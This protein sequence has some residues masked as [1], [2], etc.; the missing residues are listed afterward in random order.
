[1]TG[2]GGPDERDLIQDAGAIP[3]L[4]ALLRHEVNSHYQTVVCAI[5]YYLM[6]GL[7][8][9]EV[10][11]HYQNRNAQ[12]TVYDDGIDL[13]HMA[14]RACNTANKAAIRAASVI[15]L[16]LPHARE[17]SNAA[18]ALRA[19]ARDATVAAEVWSALLLTDRDCW[20]WMCPGL[21]SD[22][23][24][25]AV[26]QLDTA[27]AGNDVAQLQAAIEAATCLCASIWPRHVHE[28]AKLLAEFR[29]PMASAL[30]QARS[31]ITE[32]EAEAARVQKLAAL[33][34]ASVPYPDDFCCPIT[35]C[36]LVDPVVA[37]D[38]HTYERSAIAAVIESGN[39]RSPL[40]R[41][42]LEA[43]LTPN[44]ALH[45]RM[46]AYEAETLQ[47]AHLAAAE[48]QRAQQ[49]QG[50]PQATAVTPRGSGGGDVDGA[51][52][53]GEDAAGEPGTVAAARGKRG[54][55]SADA[56]AA[57]SDGA[58]AS[59]GSATKRARLDDDAG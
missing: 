51:A 6:A 22:L 58:C 56:E 42:M 28:I 23:E 48:A 55:G 31:R 21:L 16:L 49:R 18:R 41:E 38:G 20:K 53:G 3:S 30:S 1:M 13:N 25:S 9:T 14:N 43:Y 11:R 37:S 39:Q 4:V 50:A 24:P 57:S 52:A 7:P 2:P 45:R 12:H 54:G 47:V 19:L 27:T 29:R 46:R 32:L 26:K 34:L 36:R 33:G 8:D 17:Q 40:T 10:L 15:P 5:L 35:F 44:R 59:G